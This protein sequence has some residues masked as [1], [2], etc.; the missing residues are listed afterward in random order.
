MDSTRVKHLE[1]IEE[2]I[3]RMA[4]H[5]FAI[6]TLAVTI[7]GGIATYA[8]NAR[9]PKVLY[10]SLLVTLVF[11]FL[12]AFYLRLER[13][14]RRLFDEV[15]RGSGPSDLDMSVAAF[16]DSTGW[17]ASARSPAL[18]PLY[19]VLLL[20]LGLGLLISRPSGH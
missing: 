7:V 4:Q 19:L 15:R 18:F 13:L 17:S 2:T 12:D 8:I 6:R 5:C 14:Y 20:L 1:F 11:W 9:D 3:A 16:R 10:G